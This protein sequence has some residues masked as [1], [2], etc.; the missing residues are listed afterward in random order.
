MHGKRVVICE[1]ETIVQM[2]FRR[3]LERAGFLVVGQATTGQEAVEMVLQER[4]DIVLMDF[5]M[6][7]MNGIEASRRILSTYPVH[8]L[9][10]TGRT[11]ADIGTEMQE[12]GITSFLAKPVVSDALLEALER[13]C[14]KYE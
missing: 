8:I 2:Q 13:F 1:D 11:Q 5:S 10:L 12:A 6:P 7:I 9:L 3:A 4:P 14:G